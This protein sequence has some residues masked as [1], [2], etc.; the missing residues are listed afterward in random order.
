MMHHSQMITNLCA[1]H[2][3]ILSEKHQ[4]QPTL[5]NWPLIIH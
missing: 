3:F 2:D 1:W 5:G 4:K